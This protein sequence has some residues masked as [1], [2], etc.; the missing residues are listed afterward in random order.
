MKIKNEKVRSF[1]AYKKKKKNKNKKGA[2]K[3]RMGVL[4]S[5]LIAGV[6][7]GNLSVYQ[8]SSKLRY[9]VYYLE[10]DLKKQNNRLE[11]LQIE[12]LGEESSNT[13]EKEATEKL[14]MIYPKDTQKIYITVEN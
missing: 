4:L 14:D 7:I 5:I 13:I 6:G 10:E 12:N 8:I 2:L 9:E 3:K 1:K 11:T